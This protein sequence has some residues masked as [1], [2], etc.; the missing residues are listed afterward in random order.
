MNAL[1]LRTLRSDLIGSLC[2]ELNIAAIC[3]LLA[4]SVTKTKIFWKCLCT[5]GFHITQI[6][7]YF[8]FF[9]LV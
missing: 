9:Q 6:S 2:S 5:K 3:P 7:Q 8:K 4:A 1:P